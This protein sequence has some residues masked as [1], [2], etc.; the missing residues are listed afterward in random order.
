M[1]RRSLLPILLIFGIAG[2]GPKFEEAEPITDVRVYDG[3]VGIIIDL[4]A[5]GQMAVVQHDEIPGFMMAMTM[6]FG[7]REDSIRKAIAVG[8]SIAFDVSFDGIDSWISRVSVLKR[9]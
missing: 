8:D 4:V 1:I 2:C 9:P 5:D 7:L 3:G 6:P